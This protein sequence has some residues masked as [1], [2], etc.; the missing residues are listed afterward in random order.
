VCPQLAPLQRRD[1][2]FPRRG[3]EFGLK[4]EG[5]DRGAHPSSIG[6]VGG[7]NKTRSEPTS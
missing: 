6:S 7:E 2:S 4:I 3:N 5:I 1:D